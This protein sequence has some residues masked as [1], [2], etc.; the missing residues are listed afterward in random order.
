[1]A[2]VDLYSKRMKRQRGEVPDVYQYDDLPTP[3]RVQIVHIW[4]AALGETARG[5]DLC[6]GWWRTIADVLRREYCVLRL[7]GRDTDGSEETEVYGFF[8]HADVERALDVVEVVFGTIRANIPK[9]HMMYIQARDGIRSED[10]THRIRQAPE[11][12]IEELNARF[13]EHGIGYRLEEG[14]ILRVDSEFVHAEMVK[15]VLMLLHDDAFVGPNEEFLKAHDHYRHGRHKEC[16]NETLKA[17]ESTMKVICQRH[18]WAIQPTD[19]ASKLIQAVLANNLIPQA[20]Q[21]QFSSLRTVLESGTPTVRN[22]NAGHGQGATP[23]EV[24]AYLAA[25]GLHTAA[26]NILFLIEAD[27]AMATP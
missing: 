24:P 5:S 13:R 15:P 2:V 11:H 19:T 23:V 26:A 20:M 7:T 16:L 6:D 3:L 18:G 21:A 25:Y 22:K 1:M 12:A 8:I 10:G 9:L 4:R 27:K 14:Q 17:F